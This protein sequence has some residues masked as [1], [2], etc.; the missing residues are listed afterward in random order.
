MLKETHSLKTER[1][2]EQRMLNLRAL[3][4][5]E[6]NRVLSSFPQEA[7]ILELGA[8]AGWQ[9]LTL[10]SEGH[11]VQAVDLKNSS[12]LDHAV[13][14]VIPYDGH[15]LPFN[16]GSFDVVFSSNVL[17]HIQ[18]LDRFNEEIH[19]VLKPLGI[20]IHVLP[21]GSWRFWTSITHPAWV[22]RRI[23]EIVQQ[24]YMTSDS[25]SKVS[26]SAN[27]RWYHAIWPNRHGEKGNSLTELY[28]FSRYT[29]RKHFTC[30][31]WTL[32]KVKPL[33]IFYTGNQIF[34]NHL[35]FQLRSALAN[36][37]GSSSCVYI[38]KGRYSLSQ[39]KNATHQGDKN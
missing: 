25:L 14:P 34:H 8:G 2:K 18:H 35:N 39:N 10:K 11:H 38:C 23:F 28:H 20:A 32:L 33:G 37:F 12:Y 15:S 17:E 27:A 4:N 13:F 26:I 5:E 1:S 21:T 9:A 30:H 22:I 7:H 6:L 36:I 16:S 29:W 19:R 31:G 24:R 3:R